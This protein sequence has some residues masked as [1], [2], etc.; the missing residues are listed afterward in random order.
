MV[1]PIDNFDGLVLRRV[2]TLSIFFVVIT[3]LKIRVGGALFNL[4]W[5]WHFLNFVSLMLYKNFSTKVCHLPY[6]M[7]WHKG[8]S[9][10]LLFYSEF[11]LCLKTGLRYR[12]VTTSLSVGL[13]FYRQSDSTT[14]SYSQVSFTPS[15]LNVLSKDLFSLGIPFCRGD[16]PGNSEP[17]LWGTPT[18]FL[19]VHVI[20]ELLRPLSVS[21]TFVNLKWDH[22][23]GQ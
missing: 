22:F 16:S 2:K 5:I 10:F 21:R 8:L 15:T 12:P 13:V 17:T 18:R 1:I 23:T 19:L 20:L 14:L 3:T 4:T 9:S 6:I 11:K 7:F